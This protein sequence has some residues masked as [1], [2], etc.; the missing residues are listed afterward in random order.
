M[1]SIH[2]VDLNPFAV[3]IAR[4]RLTVAGLKAMGERSLVG[5]P[6]LGYH[7][8][9]GD[10][11]LGEQGGV[12]AQLPFEE[13]EDAEK[14]ATYLYDTEDLKEYSGILSPGSTTWSWATR[15]T[16]RSRTRRSTTL[17]AR[18]TRRATGS[19][20]C[21]CRSWSCSSGWRSRASRGRA[22]GYVGQI[23]SNSFM[24]R[25]FGKKLIEDLFGG[26][27]STTRST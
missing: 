21:R 27:S 6:P 10:S 24:K 15:R 17:T 5:V 7:L 23:T 20:R 13:D 26:P 22:P 11:L 8:A 2:G 3:A 4:F 12:P 18:R 16:S 19:T 1:D 25:E 9:I 14:K